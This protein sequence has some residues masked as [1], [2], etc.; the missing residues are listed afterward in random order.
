MWGK[1]SITHTLCPISR[2]RVDWRVMRSV[3]HVLLAAAVFAVDQ[4]TKA[5]AIRSL[6]LGFSRPFIGDIVR[7]TRVHNP[8]GAFGLFPQHTGAFI[9]VSA[10][11]VAVLGAVLVFGR[12]QG[13]ARVGSA[14]L[15]GGAA[16]NLVDRIRWGYVLDFL[17]VPGFPVI[18]IAD[19]A[20][21]VGAGLVALA[22][23]A[24]GKTK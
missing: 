23:L 3:R 4:G 6:D 1:G 17:E 18:N 7:L 16:G 22:L 24:G 2:T 13:L 20:I 8:G 10:V 21:V 5:W 12:W 14:L 11:V 19:S 15:L 9:A